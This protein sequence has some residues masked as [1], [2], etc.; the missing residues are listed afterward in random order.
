[1]TRAARFVAR[2][3]VA[4]GARRRACGNH[5]YLNHPGGNVLQS[6]RW[7]SVIRLL[8]WALMIMISFQ[9]FGGLLVSTP[10]TLFYYY[11][12]Q[13]GGLLS[14]AAVL[15]F[16]LWS[17]ANY[18]LPLLFPW[19]RK[20]MEDVKADVHA[21]RHGTLPSPGRRRGLSSFVHGL[22]LLAVTGMA[23][24]GVFIFLTVPG[25]RGAWDDTT[26]YGAFTDFVLLHKLISYLVWIYWFGHVGFAAAHLVRRS[27]GIG[28]IFRIRDR[29]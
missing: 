29:E 16:W 21:M 18:D 27:A 2:M 25:G 5:R 17:Y 13:R 23:V 22:G 6:E 1:M 24:T 19:S 11:A 3:P 28:A 4:P 10:G 14:A 26:S 12:H 8:H 15:V 7:D 20:G 9:L